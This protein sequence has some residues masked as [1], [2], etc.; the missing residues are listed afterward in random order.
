MS[1]LSSLTKGT[2]LKAAIKRV[3]EARQAEGGKAEQLY[4]SA[5]QGFA[6]VVAGDLNTSEALYHWGFALL[7]EAKNKDTE[8]ASALYL[9]AIEKF[10]FCLLSAPSHLGA[11]IDGGVAY[12]DL[13]RINKVDPSDSLY[14]KAMVFF[15]KAGQIQKGSA[16]YN[17]ACIN[18]L[19]GN[20]ESC[21]KALELAKQ[22]GSMPNENDVMNDPDMASVRGAK[23]FQEFL[24]TV[25]VAQVEAAE[26]ER[27]SRRGLKKT[28]EIKLDLPPRPTDSV[29]RRHFDSMVT[30]ELEKHREMEKQ[31]KK[32]ALEK[33]EKKKGEK[34]NYYK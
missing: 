15:D 3:T 32:D 12:M 10:S 29:L 1:I 2:T 16:A 30:A 19:R 31:Q 26:N 7:H 11:A 6:K 14:D 13:A 22:C 8:Q 27:R 20:K 25:A 17:Q 18:A 34:F 23:W 28:E 5:Y 9:E 4:S 33:I 24:G 21:L